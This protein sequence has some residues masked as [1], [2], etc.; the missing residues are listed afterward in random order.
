MA[1]NII[2]TYCTPSI[3][4]MQPNQDLQD[5][6]PTGYAFLGFFPPTSVS[7]EIHRLKVN[8]CASYMRKS[9]TLF[10]K[11][12]KE[13]VLLLGYFYLGKQV[14]KHCWA[15]KPTFED[16]IHSL[17]V[18]DHVSNKFEASSIPKFTTNCIELAKASVPYQIQGA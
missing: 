17:R 6:R 8:M 15:F 12:L 18:S 5:G 11:K 10:I 1:F 9:V 16:F 7:L 3:L 13:S 2:F 14:N 4:S